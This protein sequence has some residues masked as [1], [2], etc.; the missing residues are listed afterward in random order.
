MSTRNAL[1]EQDWTRARVKF[2]NV[3]FSGSW[4]SLILLLITFGIYFSGSAEYYISPDKMP[5]YW[6]ISAND[7]NHLENTPHNWGWLDL[8]A[9]GDYWV[10]APIAILLCLTPICSFLI[11]P[12]VLKHKDWL[13]MTILLFLLC[14]ICLAASGLL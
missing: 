14:T 8:L 6:Q 13:F 3:L 2:A 12:T 10:F 1:T 11:I 7:F 5:A 9:Y 4:Y